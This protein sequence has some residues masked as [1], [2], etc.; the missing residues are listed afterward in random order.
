MAKLEFHSNSSH[1]IGV[2]IELGI[3]DAETQS[4]GWWL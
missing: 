4:V 2:E 3:V 1:T